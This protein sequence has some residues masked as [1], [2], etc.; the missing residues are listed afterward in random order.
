MWNVYAIY[1]YIYM[2][3]WGFENGWLLELLDEMNEGYVLE[4]V[5]G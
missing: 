2:G 5:G 3:H 1:W 4:G